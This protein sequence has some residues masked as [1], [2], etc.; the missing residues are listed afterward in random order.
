VAELTLEV[1]YWR[2]S[3]ATLVECPLYPARSLD[4]MVLSFCE[5]S[6][7]Q[8]RMSTAWSLVAFLP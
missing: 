3:R 5:E 1:D 2:A 6:M 4:Y 7:M 8:V